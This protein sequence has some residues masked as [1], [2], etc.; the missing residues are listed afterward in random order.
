MEARSSVTLNAVARL[1]AVLYRCRVLS[2][3]VALGAGCWFVLGLLNGGSSTRSLLALSV[4][5]WAGVALGIGFSLLRLPPRPDAADRWTMR[6]RKRV[7]QVLYWLAA[8]AFLILILFSLQLS[9]RALRL[10]FG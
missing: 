4:L 6:L 8:I 3:L 7:L 2:M 5:L 9:L 1:A 10:A